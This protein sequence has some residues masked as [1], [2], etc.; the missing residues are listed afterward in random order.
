MLFRITCRRLAAVL[1]VLLLLGACGS[2][3]EDF[4]ASESPDISETDD[5]T[6][7]AGEDVNVV[8]DLD[9]GDE[10]VFFEVLGDEAEMYGVI[11]PS[12]PDLVSELLEQHP[13]VD[14][15]VLVDV[16]GSENDEANIRAA[17]LIHQAGIATHVPADGQIASGGVDFFLAGTTRTYESG[18]EFGVHSW[19]DSE[20][21]TGDEIPRDDPEHDLFLDFYSEIGIDEAFYWFTLGAAPAEEIH[22]MTSD[23]LDR[24]DI[25]ELVDA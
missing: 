1:A 24:F 21:R 25:G 11:G 5:D 4:S 20:G 7:A 3:A 19:A 17:E 9:A 23:E 22:V 8:E 10:A 6:Q 16:P 18:A 14:T 13:E 2:D 12:T 15:I